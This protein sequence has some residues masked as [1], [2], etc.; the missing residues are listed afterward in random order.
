MT[1]SRTLKF[2]FLTWRVDYQF[3]LS[4]FTLLSAIC[5]N[6]TLTKKYLVFGLVP[7]LHHGIQCQK[8]WYLNMVVKQYLVAYQCNLNFQTSSS[9]SVI[10]PMVMLKIVKL[11]YVLY[12]SNV[13]L[14]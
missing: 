7:Y 9:I 8:P 4:L 13:D 10:F 3:Q 1:S 14:S 5:Q 11:V 2:E 12:S 6:R